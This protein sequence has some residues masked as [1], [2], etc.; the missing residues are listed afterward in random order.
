MNYSNKHIT[1][2]VDKDMRRLPLTEKHTTEDV[3]FNATFTPPLPAIDKFNANR[4]IYGS[5]SE[6]TISIIGRHVFDESMDFLSFVLPR[7]LKN[8]THPI[9]QWGEGGV[10]ALVATSTVP[11]DGRDGELTITQDKNRNTAHAT[12]NFDITYAGDTYKVNGELFVVA[13]GPL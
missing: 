6:D 12:F 11:Y 3:Y 2:G 9:V 13:T 1:L 5:L 7:D 8:G 10:S 4:F